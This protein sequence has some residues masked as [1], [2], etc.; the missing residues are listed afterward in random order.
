MK[1]TTFGLPSSPR[2]FGGAGLGYGLGDLRDPRVVA[3]LIGERPG[4]ATAQSLSA[5]TAYRPRAIDMPWR[6]NTAIAATLQATTSPA[7]IN[8]LI[9]KT[10]HQIGSRP[11]ICCSSQYR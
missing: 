3:L 11:M 7:R 1:R 10:T 5:S 4:L 2:S 9:H 6:R 8:W